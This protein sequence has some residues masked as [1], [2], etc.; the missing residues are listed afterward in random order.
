MVFNYLMY[1]E[2]LFGEMNFP[3]IF[4]SKF[5]FKLNCS[6]KSFAC[7]GGSAISNPPEVWASAIII[8]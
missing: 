8:C 2:L 1:K 6:M 7:S 4:A 3:M 5:D